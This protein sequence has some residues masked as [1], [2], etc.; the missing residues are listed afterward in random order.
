MLI[1]VFLW[2]NIAF[3]F[4]ETK[5][6]LRVPLGGTKA[7][8]DFIDKEG[9][10][11]GAHLRIYTSEEKIKLIEQIMTETEDEIKREGKGEYFIS[12]HGNRPYAGT[13]ANYGANVIRDFQA[14]ELMKPGNKF[15]DIGAG[16]GRMLAVAIAL[17][18]VGEAIGFE[19]DLY[20]IEKGQKAIDRLHDLGV[21]DKKRIRWIHGAYSDAVQEISELNAVYIYPPMHEYDFEPWA[22]FI[23]PLMR[24]DAYLYD[25]ADSSKRGWGRSQPRLASNNNLSLAGKKILIVQDH[26]TV[27]SFQK[28]GLVAKGVK[29]EDIVAVPDWGSVVAAL[30]EHKFNF[31]AI[32]LDMGFPDVVIGPKT[33]IIEGVKDSQWSGISV[34]EY[35]IANNKPIPVVIYSGSVKKWE[36]VQRHIDK[37]VHP[38]LSESN[39]QP[40]FITILPASVSYIGDTSKAISI[41][42]QMLERNAAR[43]MKEAGFKIIFLDIDGVL[44]SYDYM[45][46]LY[47]EGKRTTIEEKS[48]PAIDPKAVENLRLIVEKT[49][50]KIV[51]IS[52]WRSKGLQWIKEFWR[53]NQLPGDIIDITSELDDRLTE[54]REWLKNKY[55]RSYV[56]LDDDLSDVESREIGNVIEVHPKYGLRDSDVQKVVQI[57]NSRDIIPESYSRENLIGI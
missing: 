33:V 17:T 20:L 53:Q 15:G 12:D 30:S 50:A 1:E 18:E 43:L 31:D 55:V 47:L 25:A 39:R 7:V 44:N 22:D 54:M 34:I 10:L 26:P 29:E 40:D 42:E 21:L 28:T 52:N 36:D 9:V 56:V 6:L 37:T 23:R 35:L 48:L 16:I 11:E 14:K 8:K 38:K 24:Q 5:M 49:G 13:F 2:Q 4:I 45:D 32:I 19:K 41:I 27:T 57:L 46:V 51:I 3:C